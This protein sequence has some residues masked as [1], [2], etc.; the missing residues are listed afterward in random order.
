MAMVKQFLKSVSGNTA[1][2]FA[3]ASPPLLCA[4]GV[5]VDFATFTM[6]QQALQT[7]ADEAALASTKQLALAGSSDSVIKAAAQTFLTEG[8][9]GKDESAVGTATIDRKKGSVQ[10]DVVEE[11]TP[12][13][14]QFIGAD[15][16]PVKVS[17]TAT[18]AGESRLCVLAL[19]QSSYKA[20]AMQQDAHLQANGC[21]V[22]SN[23]KNGSGIVISDAAT[24]VADTVCSAGGV[25]IKTGASNKSVLTDCPVMADPLASHPIPSVGACNFNNTNIK[26]GTV[27]LQP[28]V[29]CGGITLSKTANVSFAPGDYFITGGAFKVVDSA[30]AKGKDVAFFF[31][32]A[33]ST[34]TFKDTATIDLSGRETGNLAGLLFFDDPTS[35]NSSNHV[36]SATNAINLTGT[37]YLPNASLK[38]DPTSNVGLKSAYTVIIV[39]KISIEQGPDLILNTDYASTKVPVPAG[40]ISS[41]SVVLTN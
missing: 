16:T 39:K 18:M 5:G 19:E 4:A 14:A 1:I 34:I 20:I 15:I 30:M 17:S 32:G 40:I 27:I 24:I 6:K 8:L 26:T 41:S 10:V 12:F 9:R 22:Y 31:T 25:V 35:G 2:M 7:A 38:I 3:L 33:N 37:I 11:W 21:S 28:G 23:S 36:I 13:F 29:Y